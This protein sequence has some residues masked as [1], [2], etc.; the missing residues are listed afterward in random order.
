MN[1]LLLLC[2]DDINALYDFNQFI[3]GGGTTGQNKNVG[4]FIMHNITD[5]TRIHHLAEQGSQ[6]TSRNVLKRYDS[7][8]QLITYAWTRTVSNHPWRCFY[9][10]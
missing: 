5:A 10:S 8:D 4:G 7:G 9:I 3:N 1:N 2:A 6:V